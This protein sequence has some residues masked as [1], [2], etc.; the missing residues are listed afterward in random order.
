[1]GWVTEL[2]EGHSY[3]ASVLA[4][5][6][7]AG[8]T[9]LLQA[10]AD[11]VRLTVVRDLAESTEPR[12]CGSLIA[13]VTKSTLSHHMKILREAGIIQMRVEGT[14]KLTSLRRKELNEAYPGLLDSIL[15]TPVTE[16]VPVEAVAADPI[17]VS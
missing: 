4:E 2:P 10:L 17:P 14:R 3:D 11:P 8:I 5:R 7:V 13:S 12:A 6:P 9:E 1:M 15:R 16:A